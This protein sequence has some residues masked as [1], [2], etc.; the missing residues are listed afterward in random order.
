[1]L[2]ISL[3][4]PAKN[5]KANIQPLATEIIAALPAS[6]YNIEIIYIDDGSDD[7]T[8]NEIIRLKKSGLQ[9][10]RVVR[11][12]RSVG[13]SGAVCSGVA[14]AH[15]DLIVTL[16][17]DGQNN[18]ADI[19]VMLEKLP[20]LAHEHNFCLAGYRWQRKD[21]AWKRFQSKI[22]NRVRSAL[23][24]DDTPDSGCGL[25][26]FPRKL[27]L[28][29]PQFDHMHRFIPALVR[30]AGGQVIVVPVSHRDRQAGVSKYTM[31]NRL[32]VGIVDMLGV[33]WLQRRQCQAEITL[34]DD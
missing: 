25:K 4:I 34:R 7:G 20:P 6:D 3:V 29:L 26:V 1:M 16:D 31:W 17:A 14:A 12:A 32:W 33:M 19:P 30:R 5:E 21:T 22:A 28:A 15:Y 8:F 23:L 24:Q 10:L 2:N 27:F 9:Q 18:P 13:Q 11:H